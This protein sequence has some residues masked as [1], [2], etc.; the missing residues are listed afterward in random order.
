MSDIQFFLEAGIMAAKKWNIDLQLVSFIEAQPGLKWVEVPVIHPI[1]PLETVG[2]LF[3]TYPV[4]S[5]YHKS[6]ITL[7]QLADG[8]KN[9]IWMG[10]C[11]LTQTIAWW[12]PR[13]DYPRKEE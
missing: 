1:R 12:I 7:E 4:E 5:T 11:P 6:K 13:N 3:S 2:S 9:K 8:H 10:F